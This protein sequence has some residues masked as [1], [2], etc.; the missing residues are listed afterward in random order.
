MF[1]IWHSREVI[2]PLHTWS[3]VSGSIYLKYFCLC[4]IEWHQRN[5]EKERPKHAQFPVKSRDYWIF[6]T[7]LMGVVNFRYTKQT[8]C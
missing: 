4:S 7:K 5:K 8:W 3:S 6:I 1:M 2:K